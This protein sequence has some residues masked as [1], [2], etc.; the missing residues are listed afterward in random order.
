[1]DAAK[2]TSLLNKERGRMLGGG[3]ASF[4]EWNEMAAFRK[5]GWLPSQNSTENLV[6]FVRASAAYGLKGDAAS[7]HSDTGRT[8]PAARRGKGR[9]ASQER[10]DLDH[11][12]LQH[13]ARCYADGRF[14]P[15]RNSG[16]LL[17]RGGEA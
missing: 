1:M 8:G 5:G 11:P 16:L 6:G 13:R 12:E 2:T 9:I 7:R 14:R 4:R 3:A 10:H 15:K 17:Q